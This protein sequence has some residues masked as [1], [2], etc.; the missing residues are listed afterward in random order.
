MT[1]PRISEKPDNG[2]NQAERQNDHKE[3]AAQKLQREN[4]ILA[5][6]GKEKCW[7]AWLGNEKKMATK[8]TYQ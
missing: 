5:K 8:E 3:S 2:K 7:P 6:K 1:T 4:E